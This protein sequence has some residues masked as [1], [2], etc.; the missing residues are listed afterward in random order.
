[1]GFLPFTKKPVEQIIKEG[2]KNEE[3]LMQLMA[4]ASKRGAVHAKFFTDAHG[5]DKKA[6]EDLLI[7]LTSRITKEKGVLYCK[8]EIEKS[9]EAG[10][11]YSSFATI[12]ILTSNFNHLV[13]LFVKYA[14]G[15]VEILAPATLSI[16]AKE[17]QDILLDVSQAAQQ[18]STF[19]FE[20]SMTPQQK[21]EFQEKLKRKAEH[22]AKLRQQ[23]EK[24]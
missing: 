22:G 2:V 3:E 7:E 15:G 1:M 24:K 16:P 14:P 23:A 8:G 20:K 13:N 10:D 12:E 9:I 21:Q 6:T 5:K 17:A 4:E 19:I 11:L 18:Y